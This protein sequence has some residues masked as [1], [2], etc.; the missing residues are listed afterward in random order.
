MGISVCTLPNISDYWPATDWVEHRTREMK[1]AHSG[2]ILQQGYWNKL[3]RESQ[4]E[5]VPT[6]SCGLKIIR[7]RAC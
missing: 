1:V 2:I 3:S 7:Q 6:Q 4:A 5:H